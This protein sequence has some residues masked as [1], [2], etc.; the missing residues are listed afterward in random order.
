MIISIPY[1]DN[2]NDGIVDNKNIDELTLDAYWYDEN[3][4]DWK[5]LSDALIFPEENIVTVKTSHFT[6]FGIAGAENIS[7]PEN[8]EPQNSEA[9]SGAGG[10]CF[11][12][13][14][15]FG[16]P[17][18]KEVIVLKEFRDRY[19]LKS[20]PGRNFVDFYY[21]SSPPL[22]KFIKHK[23]LIRAFLRYHFKFLVY[24]IKSIL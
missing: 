18:A 8:P 4:G 16:S 10:N 21:H 6:V 15:A 3:N 24:L 7:Q 22:A 12:A 1:T 20:E 19:L 14:A 9:D 2:N 13:T 5:I 23:P 11:I 17:L